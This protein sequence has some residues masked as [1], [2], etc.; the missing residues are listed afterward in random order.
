MAEAVQRRLWVIGEGHVSDDC[1]R[2]LVVLKA[3]KSCVIVTFS[4]VGEVSNCAGDVLLRCTLSCVWVPV[5]AS[6]PK[7]KNNLSF[8]FHC[9]KCTIV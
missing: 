3:V 8:I 1:L 2:Q 6:E 5:F 4:G 9:I 7:G